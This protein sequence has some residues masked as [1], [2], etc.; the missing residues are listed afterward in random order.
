[1]HVCIQRAECTQMGV[2]DVYIFLSSK[3]MVLCACSVHALCMRCA[4]AVQNVHKLY[5]WQY[6]SY[7]PY[8]I[9]SAKIIIFFVNFK[10]ELLCGQKAAHVYLVSLKCCLC[11][12]AT[13]SPHSLI[14]FD[15]N[16][17]AFGYLLAIYQPWS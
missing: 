7:T 17:C 14:D 8:F 13:L 3:V 15:M 11:I 2:L 1:M 12:C 5:C 6:E 4:C 10:N 9:D 16:S